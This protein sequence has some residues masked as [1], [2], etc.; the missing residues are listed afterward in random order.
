[1]SPKKNNQSNLKMKNI[2]PYK[3]YTYT[4]MHAHIYTIGSYDYQS[5]RL[6]QC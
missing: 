5:Q 2:M 6:F 1:M 3:I 4:D